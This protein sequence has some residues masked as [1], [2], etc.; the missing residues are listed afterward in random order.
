VGKEKPASHKPNAADAPA[1]KAGLLSRLLGT[2][3]GRIIKLA[4]LLVAIIGCGGAL[5][6][7]FWP[8][9]KA[10]YAQKLA[11]AFAELDKGNRAFARQAA[12]KLLT[13][14]SVSYSEHGGAYYILGIITLQEADE[15]INLPKRQMLD[16]VAARYLEEAHSRGMPETRRREG[17]FAL[18]RAFHDADRFGRSVSALQEALQEWPEEATRIHAMLAESYLRMQPP[19]LAEALDHNQQYLSATTLTNEERDAGIL[20][21]GRILLAQKSL[22]EAEQAVRAISSDSPLYAD[23]VIL[24]GKILLKALTS[25]EDRP[26]EDITAAAAMQDQLRK[27]LA[28]NGLAVATLAQGQLLLGRLYEEQGDTR[29]AASQYDAVRRNFFGQQEAT[30]ATILHADLIRAEHPQDAVALYKRVLTHLAGSEEEYSN[31]WLPAEEFRERISVA[32]DDLAEQG[33]FT[34][35]VELADAL[36][37]PVSA[38]SK[39]ERQASIQRAWARNLE[40]RAQR[41][42]MPNSSV[43]EAEARQHWREAGVMGRKL[44]TL[45]LATRQFPDDLARAAEDFR[46][47]HGYEQAAAVY[48]EVLAQESREREPEALAGLGEALLSLSKPDEALTVLN[49]CAETYPRHPIAY[50]ARLL[51]SL[52]LMEDGK[53]PA[54]KE[55]LSDNLYSYS[56]APESIDWR[57]S[58]FALGTVLYRQAVELESK[59]R[60]VGIDRAGVEGRR[61][62]LALLEQAHAAFEDALRTLVEAVERYPEALQATEARYRIAESHR[63]AA[64]LP[65]K[66]LANVT[67]QTSI[68][69]L[70]RQ[71]QEQLQAAVDA[72][73]VLI[74]R[75]SDK[76]G[77]LLLPLEATILRN[78]YFCRADAL[79]DM[80]RFEEA[81]Q[82]YSAATNRYQHDPESLEAYVQIASCYR[83][84]GRNSEARRTLEQARVVLERVRPDADFNRT[85]RLARQEWAQL[86]DWLRT[87]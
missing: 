80:A 19:K 72:Y 20:L 48:R 85:T 81:I 83:R 69:A 14:G 10:T 6:L 59:S 7:T 28:R 9:A 8:A 1:A 44:A 12:A 67:I 30:A 52:A 26:D 47:G 84:L 61:E 58:L 34:D 75:L 71:M 35:A 56:L 39:L 63:H 21:S 49:R 53:L 32:I 40:D 42:A 18:G 55:L 41:E 27:L 50:R 5:T 77:S 11:Q 64:K 4:C 82:A 37:A 38:M 51:A 17:L 65:R 68:A 36:V 3:R 22:R 25:P 86:L 46:R 13:D 2:G 87:L 31:D 23:A 43:T 79:F 45:R 66:R 57:D 60:L 15:Q 78:C 54:A 74:T 73:N 16:L 29:T 62:G 33:H 76:E 70:H 24:Q